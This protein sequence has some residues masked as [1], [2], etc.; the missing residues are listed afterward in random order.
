MN[1]LTLL[2]LVLV[3]EPGFTAHTSIDREWARGP[4]LQALPKLR[5]CHAAAISPG[6]ACQGYIRVRFS[7]DRAGGVTVQD[8][9]DS[10]GCP[11]L[12][13]C[14]GQVFSRMVYSP[15]PNDEIWITYPLLFN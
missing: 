1:L 8:L 13:S 7:I 5:A 11:A 6:R 12:V 14:V 9:Q 2:V 4:I 3:G 10:T 15:A